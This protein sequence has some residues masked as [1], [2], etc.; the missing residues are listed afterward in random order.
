VLAG[1]G[2][3]EAER[4]LKERAVGGADVVDPQWSGSE[5]GIFNGLECRWQPIRNRNGAIATLLVLPRTAENDRLFCR[6]LEKLSDAGV[7]PETSPIENAQLRLTVGAAALSSEARIRSRLL[8]APL[9]PVRLA[10]MQGATALAK[11]L[12]R[13]NLPAQGVWW[14]EYRRA[15]SSNT[16]HLKLAGSLQCLLDVDPRRFKRVIEWLEECQR[17]GELAFGYHLESTAH[18]TC[19]VLDR[20]TRHFHF[21]DGSEGGYTRASQLLKTNLRG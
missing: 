3:R 5:S 7:P 9:R 11:V 14:R 4:L 10:L 21:I 18:M 12:I 13:W 19:M 2:L 17:N 15:V 1:E 8:P 20:A 6:V 16:D